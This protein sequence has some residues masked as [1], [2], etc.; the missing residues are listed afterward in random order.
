MSDRPT[1]LTDAIRNTP[2][3]GETVTEHKWDKMTEHARRLERER[4][5]LLE[6]LGNLSDQF[7]DMHQ[8]A[9]PNFNV[10]HNHAYAQARVLLARMR[11]DK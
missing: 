11:G 2:L 5:E 3:M 1:P 4:A 6:A 10:T 8:R 7:Y 9:L